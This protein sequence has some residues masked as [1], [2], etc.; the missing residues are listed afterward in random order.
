[1]I[2]ILLAIV[3][4]C[5]LG[6]AVYFMF[7]KCSPDCTNKKCGADDGCKGYCGC[8]GGGVCRNGECCTPKCPADGTCG[9]SDGC[10]NICNK[11]DDGGV[12]NNGKCCVPKCPDGVCGEDDGCEGDCKCS[13]LQDCV[14]G[15][16]VDKMYWEAETQI[17]PLPPNAPNIK[18][19]QKKGVADSTNETEHACLNTECAKGT[20]CSATQKWNNDTLRCD[21]VCQPSCLGKECGDDGCGTSCGS[22]DSDKDCVNNKCILAN[23]GASPNPP[24]MNNPRC[25]RIAGTGRTSASENEISCVNDLC[26]DPATCCDKD[27]LPYDKTTGKST[28]PPPPPPSAWI[29]VKIIG[30]LGAVSYQCEYVSGNVPAV[31]VSDTHQNCINTF[32]KKNPFTPIF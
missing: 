3:I 21:D 5:L 15:K 23:W 11:C 10:G 12:C 17:P 24:N 6:V 25:I 20:C 18:C 19:V 1:M 2:G 4:L 22:C 26:S 7:K 28:I 32:R 27:H 13:L 29:P 31:G 30:G 8:S 14:S 9:M 16:C